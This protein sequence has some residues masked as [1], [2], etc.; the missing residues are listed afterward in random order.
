M[1]SH[2][3]QAF[4]FGA[5]A[6]FSTGDRSA[7]V[8]SI[9]SSRSFSRGP[10]HFTGP[11]SFGRGGDSNGRAPDLVMEEVMDVFLATMVAMAHESVLIVIRRTTLLIV[12]G[13]F[14]AVP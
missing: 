9:G 14:V 12:V 6:I 11:S 3:R 1:F 7:F 8:F 13:I 4:L 5:P 2:L 10:N